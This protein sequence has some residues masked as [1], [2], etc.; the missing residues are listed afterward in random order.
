MARKNEAGVLRRGGS[1]V[2]REQRL[3]IS[4]LMMSLNNSFANAGPVAPKPRRD[5][6]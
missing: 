3:E 6:G 4:H 5:L 2:Q 1:V